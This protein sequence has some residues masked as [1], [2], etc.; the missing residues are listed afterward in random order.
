MNCGAARVATTRKKDT[1]IQD[2][3]RRLRAPRTSHMAPR[4][5]SGSRG[6]DQGPKERTR[7]PKNGPGPRRTDQGSAGRSRAPRDESGRAKQIRT[8]LDEPGPSKT[9]Q[10]PQDRSAPSIRIGASQDKSGPRQSEKK[11]GN[12]RFRPPRASECSCSSLSI[13]GRPRV[14]DMH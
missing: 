14:Q 9:N 13:S 10:G 11:R 8:Q 6:T 2:P 4:N 7:A 12:R 3:A 1:S 5:G